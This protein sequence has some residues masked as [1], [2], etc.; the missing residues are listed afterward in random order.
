[1]EKLAATDPGTLACMHGSSYRG[2]GA[3]LLNRLAEA[4]GAREAERL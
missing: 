1:V 3:S 4:L 2:N